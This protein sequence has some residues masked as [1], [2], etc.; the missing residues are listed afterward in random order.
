VRCGRPLSYAHTVF[1]YFEFQ[2]KVQFYIGW[3][4]MRLREICNIFN[5]R[6]FG[7]IHIYI[8]YQKWHDETLADWQWVQSSTSQCVGLLRW[9]YSIK[10]SS[11]SLCLFVQLH[12]ICKSQ[13]NVSASLSPH[14]NS[15]ELQ[16]KYKDR[17]VS[18]RTQFSRSANVDER[19][20]NDAVFV[21]SVTQ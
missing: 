9:S 8:F 4:R 7:D 14:P 18:D 13:W 1:T 12:S 21:K 3:R 2:L 17:R 10:R 11:S 19:Y 5:T 6:S 16:Q 20:S 15:S